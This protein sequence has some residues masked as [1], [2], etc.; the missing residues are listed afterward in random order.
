MPGD[1]LSTAHRG[2]A[3]RFTKRKALIVAKDKSKKKDKS[4]ELAA[5]FAAPSEAVSSGDGWKAEHEDNIGDLFLITPLREEEVK[6]QDYGD[7]PAIFADVVVVNVKKPAKSE[8]HENV[9]FWGGWTRGTL[10]D[11]IGKRRMLGVLAKGDAKKGQSAP[12]ILEDAD[13]DQVA[14]ATAYLDGLD[15][16]R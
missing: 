5:G 12:W 1:P 6:T 7:K 14:A 4:S 9:L 13:A 10:R 11:S 8:A 3:P 16:L 15:P 2:R